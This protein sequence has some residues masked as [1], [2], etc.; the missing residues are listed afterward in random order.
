[1]KRTSVFALSLLLAGTLLSG[2]GPTVFASAATPDVI[3]VVSVNGT[4]S[5]TSAV[6]IIPMLSTGVTGTPIALPTAASGGNRPL[7]L[8]GSASSEGQ[9]SLSNDGRYLTLTDYSASPGTGSVASMSSAASPRIGQS[10]LD[11]GGQIEAAE[12]MTQDGQRTEDLL[13]TR[14]PV[15]QHSGGLH[16]SR[17]CQPEHSPHQRPRHR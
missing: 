4:T 17:T 6:S 7:T 16:S 9:L 5:G 11:R 14:G 10:R 13:S 3:D 8:S 2:V 15:V 1:M 12:D